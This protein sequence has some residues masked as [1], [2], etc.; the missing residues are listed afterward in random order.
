MP[1]PVPSALLTSLPLTMMI[2]TSWMSVTLSAPVCWSSLGKLKIVV[3]MDANVKF[4]PTCASPSVG[5]FH[6]GTLH[7]LR[8]G[9]LST[10]A[11]TY[12]LFFANTHMLRSPEDLVTHIPWNSQSRHSQIDYILVP[13]GFQVL[14]DGAHSA[15]LPVASDHKAVILDVAISANA[16]GRG[17]RGSQKFWYLPKL[18]RLLPDPDLFDTETPTEVIYCSD[19]LSKICAVETPPLV[20]EFGTGLV[21]LDG[22]A[23]SVGAVARRHG[24]YARFAF[25]R[26]SGSSDLERLR[27]I[28]P[29]MDKRTLLTKQ[30]WRIRRHERRQKSHAH[31][32]HLTQTGRARQWRQTFGPKVCVNALDGVENRAAWPRHIADHFSQVF[33]YTSPE[34]VVWRSTL[35]AKLVARF[36]SFAAKPEL[37]ICF[38][39]D[40]V[41]TA[42]A[43]LKTG[44]AC[45]E[46]GLNAEMLKALNRECLLLLACA[47]SARASGDAHEPMSWHLLSA[48]LIPK[49]PRISSCKS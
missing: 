17:F 37:S 6:S 8:Q 41:S 45:A 48:V 26:Q 2:I 34:Y 19:V 20:N 12:G 15:L 28:E 27:R 44:K 1:G 24:S 49:A 9:L 36:T 25:P 39:V 10:L 35:R 22:F 16:K 7:G 5:P 38:S 4:G 29:D 3:G 33:S 46:D 32:D 42:I 14:G 21:P 30:I 43:S 31:L 11:D 13:Q 47:F 18:P 23:E 40:D